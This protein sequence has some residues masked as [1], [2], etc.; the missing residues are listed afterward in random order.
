MPTTK[1]NP[2]ATK[3]LYL[4]EEASDTSMPNYPLSVESALK[5]VQTYI[6]LKLSEGYKFGGTIYR[7][8]GPH[9]RAFLVFYLD[10]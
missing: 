3:P 2:E 8:V 10:N 7:E 6:A 1:P 4:V 9:T 5:D